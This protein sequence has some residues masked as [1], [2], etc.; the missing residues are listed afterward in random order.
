MTTMHPEEDLVRTVLRAYAQSDIEPLMA[1]L[2]DDIVWHSATIAKDPASH[3]G[4]TYLGRAGV[5]ELMAQIASGYT[6]LRLDPVDIISANGVHWALCESEILPGAR[7]DTIRLPMA[8]RF[9]IRGDRIAEVHV[10]FDTAFV[11][12]ER[13]A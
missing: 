6:F 4:G 10:F 1:H 2:A 13:A 12:R 5:T 3:F 7:Q 8:I 11:A 9:R